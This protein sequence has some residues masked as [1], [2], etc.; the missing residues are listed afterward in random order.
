M[1][2]VKQNDLH[3]HI[4]Q[5]LLKD[6][7][8]PVTFGDQYNFFFYGTEEV[9]INV[10]EDTSEIT[11]LMMLDGEYESISNSEL[12]KQ[13]E[14]AG[15]RKNQLLSD[16]RIQLWIYSDCH[17]VELSAIRELQKCTDLESRQSNYILDTY[18]FGDVPITEKLYIEIP[19]VF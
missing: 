9:R 18:S 12:Q 11:A 8:I 3:D 19:K 14:V 4:L 17:W 13:I 6:R 10:C 5:C 16:N 15:K 2:F 7:D 1:C